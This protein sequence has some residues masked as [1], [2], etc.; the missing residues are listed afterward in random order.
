MPLS[1]SQQKAFERMEQDLAAGADVVQEYVNVDR[2]TAES[3]ADHV[4]EVM[5]TRYMAWFASLPKESQNLILSSIQHM[6]WHAAIEKHM[7]VPPETVNL[8]MSD[9]H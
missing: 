1:E 4:G 5:Q 2:A 8:R 3:I 7:G 6:E 9:P